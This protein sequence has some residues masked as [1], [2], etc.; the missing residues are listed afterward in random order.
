[1]RRC[2]FTLLFMTYFCAVFGQK[3]KVSGSIED[4]QKEPIIGATIMEMGTSNGTT[5]DIDG[6]FT[7]EVTKGAR[8]RITYMGY[9]AMEVKAIDGLKVQM[10]EE[11]N[12]L[13]EVVAIGY[14]SV[15]RKDVTTS[16]SS[17]S[18]EDIESRPIVNALQGMQ[19]K[20]AGLSISQA[21]GQPG[22]AP[23]IR[24]RGTTSLNGSNDPLYVVDGVPVS[25]LDYLN[26]Q[27]IESMQVLKDASSAAIYGSRAANG[28]ILVTTK[29]GKAGVTKVDL[30]VHYAFNTVRDNQDPLNTEQYLDLINEM[31]E[32]GVISLNLPS[33][34]T[35][36]TDWK[37]EVYRTGNV[38]DYQL[39][40]TSGTNSLRYYIS[41]GYTGEK[42]VIVSSNFKRYN[43]RGSIEN[44]VNNWLTINASG[45]YSDYTYK[46]TG[47]ISGTTADRGGVI[48]A[49]LST[50]TY[51]P[52]WDP[53]NP[54][55]Y[56]SDFYGVNIDG[57]LENIA[58]TSNNKNQYN[59]LLLSGKAIVHLLPSLTYTGTVSFDREQG[60]TT[61]F[62]DPLLT[63]EGRN[64]N[65]TGYDA[66]YSNTLWTIDN[67]V[68]WKQDFGKH[69]FD[70]MAGSSYTRNDY[71]GNYIN[72]SDYADGTFQTLNAANTISWTGTGS[73][74][75]DW[76]L[77][78][79]FG[80]LQY[81]WNSTYMFT[82]N[83][84][85]DGSSRLAPG[86][87]WGVFPSF[88]A[89]WRVSNEKFMKDI[90]WI[91][92]L[93]IR[94]GWGQTGNQSGLGEY[95]YL[96]LYD[97]SRT[98][99]WVSGQ[100]NAVV[101]VTQS[102]L[103]N[104]ELTWETTSQWDL[105]LDLTVLK[106]R[107]TFYF[108][109]YY[110]KT[111]DMLMNIT[112]PAGSAAARSLA[113]N[114]GEIT[115]KGVEF[116]VSSK[117][118]VGRFSWNTDFN[119]S[120][121]RNKLTK[122]KF[123][124]VYWAATTTSNVGQYV[125]R[126]AVGHPLGAFYGYVCEGVDPETGDLVYKDVNEDGVISASDRTYIGDP[127]PDF[128]YGLTNTFNYKGFS[129]SIL[130]Q[131]SYGN[132]IYNVSRMESEGMYDGKNQDT[133]VLRR[134]R[135]PGQITD[136]P[137]VGFNQQNSSYYIEDGS[138]LRVKDIS[139]SYSLPLNICKKLHMTRIMPYVSVTN[140]ITW[141]DYSGRDPEVNQYGS[142]GGV[143]GIDWGTYPL[144]KSF[145]M[146]MKLEF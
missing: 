107:L 122:L 44:D 25:N 95:S 70:V 138:Y 127:N 79:V 42:G 16:V 92:D 14:G 83:L 142:S 55:Q 130:I 98:E 47:I 100:E 51:A 111:S 58:R 7:L 106:N 113:Y 29:Q 74:A 56:Y 37:K 57:P 28:V 114:G 69:S 93:K 68:D 71:S 141:T 78:S 50:P 9:K 17:I 115:N 22:S 139:L 48:P 34:L 62:L 119:I 66:R 101:S 75:S 11:V 84:R 91:D 65:G 3:I 121:N 120:F 36:Q 40:V 108:D 88:S 32:R 19:G 128:T 41:G 102:T 109:W 52:I 61:N 143:Q 10:N 144:N 30:N 131:G 46:G 31:N 97:F 59:K 2:F 45:A 77:F 125:V 23:T 140:L 126:N 112:L 12:T 33:T 96:A 132:D 116:S 60:T 49:I 18:T 67:V 110:K 21:N 81:N 35:D 53:D 145:V 39:S 103:S 136:V 80:R 123:V 26:A 13:N 20:A 118:L 15:K 117:N 1:M 105:G 87:R 63:R 99:W 104:P 137:R 94:G 4:V 5:S 134:W 43:I 133:G 54:G 76:R 73:S 146:G 82:A 38:Q 72:A 135:T 124:P 8:L 85:A 24:V 129:L 89:A 27:D 6:H 86:H 90:T 64:Q